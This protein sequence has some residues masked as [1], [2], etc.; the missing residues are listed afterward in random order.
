MGYLSLN[1]NRRI[2]KE[3]EKK[4]GYSLDLSVSSIHCIHNLY[5]Y[6]KAVVIFGQLDAIRWIN[7]HS[8]TSID[9][10]KEMIRR[11]H[12]LN[13]EIGHNISIIFVY[14]TY[15]YRH[16]KL[17]MMFEN[18]IGNLRVKLNNAIMDY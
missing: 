18:S 1:M 11:V 4:Y 15:D 16:D 17:D 9:V 13:K 10:C 12:Q 14:R 7:A 6:E 5:K 8:N 3:S 2:P